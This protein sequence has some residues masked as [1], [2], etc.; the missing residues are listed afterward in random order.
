M[1]GWKKKN[2]VLPEAAESRAGGMAVNE[3]E[4]VEHRQ[5]DGLSIFLDT[6]DYRTPHVHPEWEL[7]WVLEEPLC[8][9]C[10]QREFTVSPGEMVLFNPNEPHEFRKIAESCTFVC[11]QMSTRLLSLPQKRIVEG[12]LP[13]RFLPEAEFRELK[14]R[15]MHTA[16]AYLRQEEH[17]ELYCVGQI[18]LTMHTIFA[19]MPSRIMIAGE[20]SSIRARNDRLER[21]IRFVDENYMHK[22][23]LSDFAEAE[24]CSMTY[25]SHFV[26]ES[27]NQTFQEYVSAVRFNRACELIAEGNR[28]LLDVCMESGFSDYR[29][30]VRAFRQQYGMTPVEYARYAGRVQ[31]ESAVIH[32]SIHSMERFYT[33]EESLRILGK[34][35]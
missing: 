26:K 21:L 33:R 6:V 27:M 20:A 23:R 7:I 22:I 24:G 9:S 3:F 28:T 19:H 17:Y 8:V 25:L 31:P 11:V 13:G 18:C 15:L 4:I 35:T 5:I 16:T 29:Y 12:N 32:R 2:R 14:N 1:L 30:F 10:G 34:F